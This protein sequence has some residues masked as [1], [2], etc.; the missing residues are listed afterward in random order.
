M[1]AFLVTVVIY[2]FPFEPPPGSPDDLVADARAAARWLESVAIETPHGLA[3]PAVAD[4]ADASPE[5][6]LYHGAP[7]SILL[8][9]ELH[10]RTGKANSHDLEVARQAADDLIH[11]VSTSWL[12]TPAKEANGEECGLYTGLGGVGFILLEVADGCAEQTDA[13]R[14]RAAAKEVFEAIID[15]AERTE[16][17]VAWGPVNDVISGSAGI[18]LALLD[19]AERFEADDPGFAE[20]LRTCAR[21]GGLE[22]LARGEVEDTQSGRTMRWPI[23]TTLD[24]RYP[25]FSH[26]TAGIGFA[27]LRLDEALI[28]EQPEV[29]QRFR[30]AALAAARRLDDLARRDD[31]GGLVR[32]HEPGG[33]DLFYLGWCHG[34]AGTSR[35]FTLLA[36]RTGDAAWLEPVRTAMNT[37]LA[38]GLPN[39]RP[40][41]YWNNVGRCCGAAGVADALLQWHVQRDDPRAIELARALSAD[42]L[43]RATSGPP[44]NPRFL[45]WTHAEHRAR[46]DFLQAQTGLMQGAAGIGL[47]LLRLDA[48][49]RGLPFHDRLPDEL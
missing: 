25:N 19:A 47:W 6:N 17:G 23:S 32:H 33:E 41:G 15:R 10:H 48:H 26:G 35:F 43:S 4:A 42:I 5:L 30:A 9:L 21:E 14:Y 27:L 28:D 31:A 36:E 39:A 7:G 38:Q 12:V 22:L 37:L 18:I 20:E 46:P 29:A 49:E 34:P 45:R 24:R 44:D 8:F 11:R 1:Y 2:A 40:E 16:A 13:V 3:W